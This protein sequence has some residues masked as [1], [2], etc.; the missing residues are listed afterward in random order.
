MLKISINKLLKNLNIK[1]R[2]KIN[3]N[4]YVEGKI[5]EN[6]LLYKLY[7]LCMPKLSN[8]KNLLKFSRN[9]L[10]KNVKISFTVNGV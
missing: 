5:L 9:K 2:S 1:L 6:T 3:K 10:L 4:K 7:K 8:K